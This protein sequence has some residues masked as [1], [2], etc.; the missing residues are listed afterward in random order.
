[1]GS[2]GRTA[3]R[4]SC[5]AAARAARGADRRCWYRES[6][7]ARRKDNLQ[8]E[9]AEENALHLGRAQQ[10]RRR[11]AQD[12]AARLEHH[13]AVGE[14]ER[15]LDVLLDEKNADALLAADTAHKLA[16]FRHHARR[17]AEERLVDHQ[18]LRP[19]HQAARDGHHLLLAAGERMRE[20]RAARLE[21]GEKL[22]Q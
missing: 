3:W 12:R 22:L 19:R 6:A 5:S 13:A 20:L 2:P 17:K 8:R 4:T 15:K 18:K 9:I 21:Q 14:P 1:P 11:T 10:L 16:D 7:A